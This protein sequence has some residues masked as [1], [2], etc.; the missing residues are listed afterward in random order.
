MAPLWNF[1]CR[2]ILSNLYIE[3]E[4]ADMPATNPTFLFEKTDKFSPEDL[5]VM[6]Q[7]FMRACGENPLDTATEAQR[8]RLAEAMVNIYQQHLTQT[9]LVAAAIHAVAQYNRGFA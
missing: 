7:A 3:S 9:Q 2:L 4:D 5:Q 6:R 8:Y 1:C